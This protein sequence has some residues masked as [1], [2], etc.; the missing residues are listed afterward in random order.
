MKAIV[1][2]GVGKLSVE[3]VEIKKP[4]GDEVLI[5]VHIA[6]LCGTDAHMLAGT[7]L[8][9]TFPLIPGH[10]GMGHIVEIGPDVKTFKIGDRVTWDCVIPCMVCEVCKR[11]GQPAFC[12]NHKASGFMPEF[13]GSMAEYHLAPEERVFKLP[14]SITDEAGVLTEVVAV[15]YHAI[16]ADE[17]G[18]GVG[19]HDRV[20]IIGCGPIGLFALQIAQVSGAKVIVIEPMPS[21]IKMAEEV[22]AKYIIDPSKQNVKEEVMKLTNNLGLTK[23][24][25]CSGSVSGIASTIDLIAIKGRIVLT[26]QCFAAQVPIE[27]GKLIWKN[28]KIFASNGAEYFFPN[29]IEFLS[30]NLIKAE[31]IITH[32]FPIERAKE[33]F[34][35]GIEGKSGKILIYPDV[36]LM[37]K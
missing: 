30:K 21:R 24:I 20:G 29:V 33:A 1:M 26:G 12:L 6:G 31:K 7:N 36:T 32:R 10:E 9:G 19:P 34:E 4:V 5:K 8:E 27:L 25:E 16:W 18:G 3:D 11:G 35:L 28:A 17:A 2:R 13:P 15:P 22:G 23:I 14:D 37:P